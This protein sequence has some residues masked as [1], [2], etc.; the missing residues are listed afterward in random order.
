MYYDQ[1]NIQGMYGRGVHN[2]GNTTYRFKDGKAYWQTIDDSGGTDT[3]VRNGDGK[4]L[5]DLNVGHWSDVG[6][7]I[8][9]NKGSTKWTVMIGPGTAIENAIGGAGKDK[10]IGNGL[11]NVLSG[12]AG[13]DKLTGGLGP[14]GFQFDV[15]PMAGNLDTVSDFT[16]GQDIIRL[17]REVF[18]ALSLG[19]VSEA[20]FDAHFDYAGGVLEYHGKAVVKLTGAPAIDGDDLFVV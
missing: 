13:K 5:I 12:G 17:A 18:D 16:V 7:S 20:A 14:D 2:A 6:R 19:A 4:A 3:I 8:E 1:V 10:I 15:K 11:A 9:F